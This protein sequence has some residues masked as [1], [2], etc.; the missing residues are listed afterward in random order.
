MPLKR[1]ARFLAPA[2]K[3]A[4]MASIGRTLQIGDRSPAL[5]PGPL[6]QASWARGVSVIIPERNTPKLLERALEHLSPALQRLSEPSETIVVVNGAPSELYTS[7]RLRFPAVAW[8]FHDR[9][10]GFSGA[11]E[12]GLESAQFGGVYLHNSDMAIEPE[13]LARLLPWRAPTV[14]AIASQI[15]F[16]DPAKRREETGWGDL[17]QD[18]GRF[19][20][21]DRTPEADGL[22]RG[23]LY[24]GG[25]SSLFDI[26]LL[27]RFSQGARA[28]T[29]FYWED[30]DWGLRAWRHGLSV[31]FHPGSIVWHRHRATVSQ[32]YPAEEIARILDR[33]RTLFALRNERATSEWL[34]H[35]ENSH[36]TTIKELA[37]PSA[38]RE[39]RQ[40]RVG[41]KR[42]PFPD[43]PIERCCASIHA[44]PA[45][46]DPRPLVLVVTP[47]Q[48]LPPRH[49]GAW[50][51]WRLC[52]SLSDRWRFI[53]L[54]DERN[55]HG[56]LSW[57]HIGPFDSV[58]L[59]GGRPDGPVGR[60]GRIISHSHAGL[61]DA[62]THLIAVYQP[63]LVQLEHV[64]L[65]GLSVPSGTPSIITLHDVLWAG[66]DGEADCFERDRLA[67]FDGLIVCSPEDAALLEP[68]RATIV[69]NGAVI[70]ERLASSAGRRDLL[71]AGA[72]RYAP[73]VEG[74]RIFLNSVFPKLRRVFP[75]TDLIVLAG[76]NGRAL[77]EDDPLFRQAG[78]RIID[79][80]DD[81]QPWLKRCALTI[82]P[83]LGTR[84]SSLKLIESLAAGRVCVST[85][86][87]ARGFLDET[88]GGLLIT[89]DVAGMLQPISRMLA[90]ETERLTLER[91]NRKQLASCSWTSAA[92]RQD[93]LYRRLTA[94]S[95]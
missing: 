81:V 4:R 31:L 36:W 35:L 94:C 86:D 75:T 27:R 90:D 44:R 45:I 49:G 6:L 7:L 79:A 21:F 25:G 46:A 70:T 61:Q 50:R 65:A 33:N 84:G 42:A 64:E 37:Q 23:A 9:P 28:Y 8:R 68:A 62:L 1:C 24:A 48:I 57:T 82:N 60:I 71:F 34:Q 20:L 74:L 40:A 30:A 41:L 72:F 87:G 95:P 78:V 56:G 17:A 16:D 77:V 73:N 53:L 51:T 18:A 67:A 39:I 54:S 10:L 29:P 5:R 13:A 47:F 55:G 32:F 92:A 63:A 19:E 26:D 83:L 89:R 15:F 43:L 14:F 3:R 93:A 59:V 12:R 52:E 85:R 80:V 66:D 88:L 69:P 76:Q 22:V 38:R 2:I 11:I 58:H 91:P